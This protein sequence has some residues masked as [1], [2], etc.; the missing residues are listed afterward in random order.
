M[1]QSLPSC[2]SLKL[3]DKILHP[4]FGELK[5]CFI[6]NSTEFDDFE[7]WCQLLEFNDTIK[8]FSAMDLVRIKY[9]RRTIL[10]LVKGKEH[11]KA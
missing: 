9:K 2:Y 7:V 6:I 3:G 8:Y 1:I 11:G 4:V 10:K 5:I